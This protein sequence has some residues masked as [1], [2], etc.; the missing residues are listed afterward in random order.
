MKKK[1]V[2][3]SLPTIVLDS[4]PVYVVEGYEYGT[5]DDALEHILLDRIR[6]LYEDGEGVGYNPSSH[7]LAKWVC[8]NLDRIVALRAE[9]KTITATQKEPIDA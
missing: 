3:K 2:S 8:R 5:Y 6:L 9:I 1:S 7:E 4:R